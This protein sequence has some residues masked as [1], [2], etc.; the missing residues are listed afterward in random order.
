M[1]GVFRVHPRPGEWVTSVSIGAKESR[2]DKTRILPSAYGWLLG[3]QVLVCRLCGRTG[4]DHWAEFD[5]PMVV[6][7]HL[8]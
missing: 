3:A 5:A 4:V 8:C 7:D 2:K 1:D 6:L